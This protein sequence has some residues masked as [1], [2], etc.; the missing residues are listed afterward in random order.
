[1]HKSFRVCGADPFGHGYAIIDPNIHAKVREDARRIK[2]RGLVQ[3]CTTVDAWAPEAQESNLGRKCLDAVLSQPGWVVRILTKNA[4]VR[5]DF[6][7]IEQHKDRILIGLSMT[8]TSDKSRVISAIEPHASSIQSRMDTLREAHARGFR[9][10]AMLCPL[11][12]G[13][14]DSPGQIDQ[15]VQFAS[16]IQ[17]EE[18]FV[19]PVNAR[20]PGLRLTQEALEQAGFAAEAARVEAV[21]GVTNWSRYARRLVTNV[22][23]SALDFYDMSRLRLLLYTSRLAS[24]DLLQI[25]QDERGVIWLGRNGATRLG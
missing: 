9:T 25:R 13:I 10:Y 17:A 23:R 19:E 24:E 12:P 6:D 3:L 21:R 22:Q 15:L 2:T 14:S 20:G 5:K 16:E 8:G 18:V 4:S 7:L 1:M 11:L